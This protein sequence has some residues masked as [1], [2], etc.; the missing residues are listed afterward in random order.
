MVAPLNGTKTHPLSSHALFVLASV[1]A[2]GPLPCFKINP[3]VV[4]R[5]L[6]T[7]QVE[8]VQCA[9]GKTKKRIPHLQRAAAPAQTPGKE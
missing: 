4:N 2:R 7:G 3:G 9:Y 6:R 1:V 8:I 5:L